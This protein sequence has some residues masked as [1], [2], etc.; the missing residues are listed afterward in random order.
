MQTF[1]HSFLTKSQ[2]RNEWSAPYL[3]RF[4]PGE[5]GGQQRRSGHFGKEKSVFV[6]SNNQTTIYLSFSPVA[7]QL[8]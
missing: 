2:D 8:S 5:M 1:L 4:I 6:S 3:G 7:I